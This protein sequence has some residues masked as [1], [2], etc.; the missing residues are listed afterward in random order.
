MMRLSSII[1]AVFSMLM[2]GKNGWRLTGGGPPSGADNCQKAAWLKSPSALINWT[3]CDIMIIITNDGLQRRDTDVFGLTWLQDWKQRETA[4]QALVELNNCESQD[5]AFCFLFTLLEH[6]RWLCREYCIFIITRWECE[7]LTLT[8]AG[9]NSLHSLFVFF[10]PILTLSQ[11]L[12]VWVHVFVRVWLASVLNTNSNLN[13]LLIKCNI[14]RGE[15]LENQ[16][17]HWK[18][19]D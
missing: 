14:S 16:H 8:A 9:R 3:W 19:T 6:R 5:C 2:G 18:L 7:R 1:S 12:L 15:Q 11:R 4:S 17:L 13:R 10:F